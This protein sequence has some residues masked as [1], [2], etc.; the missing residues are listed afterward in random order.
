[1][2]QVRRIDQLPAAQD[3][4][5]ADQVA[6]WQ[7]GRTRV[8]LVDDLLRTVSKTALGLDRVDNT[9]DAEKPI[10]NAQAAALAAKANKADLGSAAGA[11]ITQLAAP[12]LFTNSDF[13]IGTSAATLQPNDAL[14]VVNV[15][16]WVMQQSTITPFMSVKRT[17]APGGGYA[18]RLTNGIPSGT[19]ATIANTGTVTFSVPPDHNFRPNIEVT[20]AYALDPSIFMRGP[21]TA[22]TGGTVTIA[23]NAVNGAGTYSEW[24]IGRPGVTTRGQTFRTTTQ[25]T[26]P[27]D[28]NQ[29]YVLYFSDASNAQIGACIET[30]ATNNIQKATYIVSNTSTSITLSKPVTGAGVPAGASITEYGAQGIY[31]YQ[32]VSPSAAKDFKNGTPDARI[33]YFSFGCRSFYCEGTRASVMALGYKSLF[34]LGTSY[35]EAFDITS[36][37]RRVSVPILGD[38]VGAPGTWVSGYDSTDGHPYMTVGPVWESNDTPTSRNIPVGQWRPDVHAVGGS[39]QQTL[40]LSARVGSWVEYWEPKLEFDLQTSYRSDLTTLPAVEEIRARAPV[41]PLVLFEASRNADDKKKWL[42][43]VNGAGAYVLAAL[44]DAETQ[45]TTAYTVGRDGHIEVPRTGLFFTAWNQAAAG[46]LLP[47]AN[48]VG[49]AKLQRFNDRVQ[50]GLACLQSGDFPA[51]AKD[52]LDA[53]EAS[54]SDPRGFRSSWAQLSVG[55][56]IGGIAVNAYAFTSSMSEPTFAGFQLGMAFCGTG[57]ND[58]TT[59]Q[60]LLTTAYFVAFRRPGAGVASGTGTCAAEIDMANEGNS[61]SL[62]PKSTY[63]AGGFTIGLQLNSGAISPFATDASAALTFGQN[64]AKWLTGLVV[65]QDAIA[66]VT[67]TNDPIKGLI[68]SGG[69]G[70]L[71]RAGAFQGLEWWNNDGTAPTNIIVSEQLTPANQQSIRFQDS[72]IVLGGAALAGRSF[73]AL[74]VG[75]ATGAWVQ[76]APAVG[77]A[78]CTITAGGQTNADLAVRSQGSGVLVLDKVANST[79]TATA[80]AASALP[81]APAGYLKIKLGDNGTTILKIPYYNT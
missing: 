18:I 5:G 73:Q 75:N 34:E 4:G 58:N 41:N 29:G 57:V 38:K 19:T 20:A 31:A 79:T 3:I 62:A 53:F 55:S 14:D 50:I 67:I 30:S 24:A 61:L 76:V 63:P 22:I 68:A 2:S 78:P 51:T 43:Y 56:E 44:N 49:A 10:S 39:D 47:P 36:T 40:A 74:Y 28:A 13:T 27:G 16:G 35:A 48:R 72:G 11:S 59:V 42:E 17:I 26:T 7:G 21:V 69:Y 15:R 81:S 71:I 37:P 25:A 32:N 45:S 66:G 80:G 52:P 77:A 1:M 60:Q 54:R 6:V 12:N 46:S 23:P 65:G 33:S 9:S 64:G 8:A 70:S